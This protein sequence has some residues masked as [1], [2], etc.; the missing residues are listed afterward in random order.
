MVYVLGDKSFRL[1][2]S[3]IKK[4]K[5]FQKDVISV[6]ERDISGNNLLKEEKVNME[7]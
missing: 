6:M 7:R 3:K 1:E 5:E 2:L 4:Y